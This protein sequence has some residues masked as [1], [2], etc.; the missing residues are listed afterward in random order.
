LRGNS[1]ITTDAGA[2]EGGNITL[3]SD[4]LVGLNNSDITAATGNAEGGRVNVN[5]P[6][7][8]GFRSSQRRTGDKGLE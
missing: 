5:V 1:R 6:N 8:L 7:I 2:A 3:N 4:I